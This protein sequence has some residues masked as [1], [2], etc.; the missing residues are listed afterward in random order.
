MAK[1]VEDALRAAGA[2]DELINAIMEDMGVAVAA[3]KAGNNYLE[4][5]QEKN[6]PFRRQC[7]FFWRSGY[8]G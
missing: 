3:V 4:N 8:S 1:N 2:G 5:S 7:D 6:Q